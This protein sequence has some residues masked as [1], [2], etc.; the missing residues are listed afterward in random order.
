[1]KLQRS[2]RAVIGGALALVAATCLSGGVAHAQKAAETDATAT[3]VMNAYVEAIGGEAAYDKFKTRRVKA[4]FS[5]PAAGINAPLTIFQKAPNL[6]RTLTEI[7]GLGKIVQ[8]C[9]GKQVYDSNPI[10]GQRLLE[11]EEKDAILLEADFAAD[12]NWQQR[13]ASV[14]SDGEAEVDGSKCDKLRL[15]TMGGQERVAYFDQ[16]SHLLVKAE[17]TVETPQ[18]KLATVS[19]LLD[20]KDVDGMKFPF[21]TEVSLLGQQQVIQIDSIEHGVEFPADTFKIPALDE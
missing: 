6:Q 9:D 2:M 8:I 16:A 5:M 10:T 17:M 20:Y 18:G 13:Y 3:R 19:R 11:G 1:M 7:P 21:K 15:V 14:K 12:V 4:T